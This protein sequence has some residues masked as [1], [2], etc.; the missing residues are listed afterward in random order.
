MALYMQ[1][2]FHGFPGMPDKIRCPGCKQCDGVQ[3]TGLMS[4]LHLIQS[5]H[6]FP[7]GKQGNLYA[8]G[9]NYKHENC[10]KPLGMHTNIQLH[11]VCVVVLCL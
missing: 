10:P 6:L 8:L 4:T 9:M 7:G 3:S 1:A 11:H 2:Q 5:S